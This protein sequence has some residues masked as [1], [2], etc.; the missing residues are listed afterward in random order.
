MSAG[1]NFVHEVLPELELPLATGGL[2]VVGLGVLAVAGRNAL[3]T[4]KDPLVPDEGLSL[5]NFFEVLTTF[6]VW[7]GDSAMGKEN[8]RFLPFA[9]ILFFYIFSMNII[10]LIPGFLMPTDQFQF[11][12]GIALCVFVLYNYWGIKEVGI[13]HYI[14]H[15]FGGPALLNKFLFPVAFLL[16]AIELVSHSVR[17][18]TLSLRLFGNMTG[19]HLALSIFTDLTK[20]TVAFF[21]PVVFYVLGTAV[22]FIQAFVF[23]LLSMIYI[24]LAT[25]H[26]EH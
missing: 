25:A 11:N 10:G 14:E 15:L 21:V 23:T 1:F 12:L 5:R 19:D 7:L 17:P 26:E 8:R 6:I 22:C 16:F 18:V 13:K 24:R 2:V 4:C 20:G 9:A 3:A